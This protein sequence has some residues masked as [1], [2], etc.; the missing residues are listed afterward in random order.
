MYTLASPERRVLSELRRAEQDDLWD[1]A[2]LWRPMTECA[3]TYGGLAQSRACMW[4]R[5]AEIMCIC[6]KCNLIYIVG[7]LCWIIVTFLILMGNDVQFFTG[8]SPRLLLG[9]KSCTLSTPDDIH[10]IPSFC[11]NYTKVPAKN[12]FFWCEITFIINYVS[13]VSISGLTKGGPPG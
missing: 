1:S 3:E 13:C 7:W 10:H 12:R 4:I 8:M 9:E 6:W 2:A 11:F 5:A